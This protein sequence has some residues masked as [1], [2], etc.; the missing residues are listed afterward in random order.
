MK[1]PVAD[2]NYDSEMEKMLNVKQVANIFG[3]SPRHV[4]E[5]CLSWK[6]KYG[7][8]TSRQPGGRGLLFEPDEIASMKKQLR[9]N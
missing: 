3:Y 7:V 1:Y 2:N 8:S 4:T 6:D 9:L 5:I